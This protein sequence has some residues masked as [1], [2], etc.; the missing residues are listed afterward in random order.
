V[1]GEHANPNQSDGSLAELIRD[2]VLREKIR[3]ALRDPTPSRWRS[4]L[5]HPLTNLAVGFL[6]T[7]VAGSWINHLYQASEEEAQHRAQAD[8]DTTRRHAELREARRADATK[9]FDTLGTISDARFFAL[10]RFH[11]AVDRYSKKEQH[12]RDSAYV[13]ATEQWQRTFRTHY[14]LVCRYF[15]VKRAHELN[16]IRGQFDY[17]R[18]AWKDD[19]R[20]GYQV[21]ADLSD[22]LYRF[23]LRLAQMLRTNELV[24]DDAIGEQCDRDPAPPEP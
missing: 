14:A 19:P 6:L 8:E 2:E 13:V 5:R 12:L 17:A 1:N 20:A 24:E 15:G 4:A 23:S 3:D 21:Q 18:N 16:W 9:L 11:Q 22:T 7:V 10:S